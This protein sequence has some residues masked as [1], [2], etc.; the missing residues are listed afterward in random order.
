MKMTYELMKHAFALGL[1][2][3]GVSQKSGGPRFIHLD[4]LEEAPR[5]SVWSY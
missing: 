4:T 5:P 2:G 1:K 3:I